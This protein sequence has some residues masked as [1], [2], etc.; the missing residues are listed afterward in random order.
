MTQR[1]ANYTGGRFPTAGN[2]TAVDSRL[3]SVML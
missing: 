2:R 3:S 1:C